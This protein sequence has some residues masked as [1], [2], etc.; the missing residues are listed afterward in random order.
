M[1]I[2]YDFKRKH[3]CNNLVKSL[4]PSKILTFYRRRQFKVADLLFLGSKIARYFYRIE[5]SM[6]ILKRS[7]YNAYIPVGIT[8]KTINL[9]IVYKNNQRCKF[10]LLFP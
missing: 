10:F 1:E 9:M 2:L 4:P 3:D 5:K 7:N 6:N 8:I